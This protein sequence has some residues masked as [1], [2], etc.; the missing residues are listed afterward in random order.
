VIV[1][2]VLSSRA[3]SHSIALLLPFPLRRCGP[4]KAIAPYIEQLA[5]DP[6]YSGVTFLK[7]DVDTADSLAAYFNIEAMPTFAFLNGGKEITSLRLKG[8]D[9]STLKSRIDALLAA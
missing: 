5:A 4:C 8:A 7:V 3:C 1:A 6:A 2:S 9:K